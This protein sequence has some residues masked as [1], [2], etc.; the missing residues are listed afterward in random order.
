MRVIYI[1][2]RQGSGVVC[3][4]AFNKAGECVYSTVTIDHPTGF[5]IARDRLKRA[6]HKLSKS[7]WASRALES[8]LYHHGEG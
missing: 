2:E 7:R 4:T 5:R 1:Y 6:G 3:H 8:H